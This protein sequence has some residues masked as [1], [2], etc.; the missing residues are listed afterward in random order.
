[1]TKLLVAQ[2]GIF[3]KGSLLSSKTPG[4]CSYTEC[5]ESSTNFAS[6]RLI[7]Y[8]LLILSDVHD[9]IQMISISHRKK[10]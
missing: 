7:L 2:L 8:Y 4:T 3:Y 1:M 10:P 9:M 5:E 6:L